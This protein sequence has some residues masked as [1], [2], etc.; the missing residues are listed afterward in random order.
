[1]KKIRQVV[2]MDSSTTPGMSMRRVAFLEGRR[3]VNHAIVKAAMPTGM[4]M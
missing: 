2:A 4:L 1:V 3:S